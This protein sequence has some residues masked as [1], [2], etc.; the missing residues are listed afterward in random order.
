MQPL[1]PHHIRHRGI[2]TERRKK[3]GEECSRQECRQ[4]CVNNLGLHR[5]QHALVVTE[6][7]RDS[8]TS[9][10]PS[11]AAPRKLPH[12]SIYTTSNNRH[13]CAFGRRHGPTR[14]QSSKTKSLSPSVP[15][16]SAEY[17]VGVT[18][19]EPR[20]RDHH[21]PPHHHTSTTRHR[22]R[23]YSSAYDPPGW[24]TGESSLPRTS[25]QKRGETILDHGSK[26]Q[27]RPTS[28]SHHH[29]LNVLPLPE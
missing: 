15:M 21:T 11:Q 13:Y 8:P 10:T 20:T 7:R 14:L 1:I 22:A 27:E 29:R 12:G 19:P 28:S 6:Y 17:G 4:D 24:P 5:Q 16:R 26:H 25:G 3:D 18:D 2:P 9:E 23:T